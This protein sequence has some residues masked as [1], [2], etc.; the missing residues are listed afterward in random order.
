MRLSAMEI[1]IITKAIRS[2]FNSVADPP[3]RL[4]RRGF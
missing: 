2:Q 1:A 3:L 4:A